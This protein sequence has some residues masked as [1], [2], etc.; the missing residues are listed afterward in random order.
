VKEC[1]TP[2]NVET[3]LVAKSGFLVHGLQYGQIRCDFNFEEEPD[4]QEGGKARQNPWVAP[5]Q[6]ASPNDRTRKSSESADCN[7]LSGQIELAI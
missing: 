3:R 4:Y 5:A 7:C 1:E 6:R 2:E